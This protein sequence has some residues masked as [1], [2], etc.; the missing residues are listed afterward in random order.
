MSYKNTYIQD[1][2]N[3]FLNHVTKGIMLSSKEYD[4]IMKWKARGVPKEVVYK[5]ISKAIENCRKKFAGNEFPRSLVYYASFVEDEIRNYKIFQEDKSDKTEQKLNDFIQR[6]LDRL[7]KV[8]T[9]EKREGMRKHYIEIRK[10]IS[11]LINLNEEDIFKLFED[12]EKE[13]YESFFQSLPLSEQDRIIS[14]AKEMI[15]KR[16]RFM[17]ERARR[18]SVLS[19]RNELLRKDHGL[20]KIISDD[21]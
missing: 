10:K 8:I 18:E 20:I 19:F 15:S 21:K 2:E 9:T 1:I 6:I 16:S 4:L 12:I 3:Y 13:F 11:G 7:A 14:K 17:T 5:G